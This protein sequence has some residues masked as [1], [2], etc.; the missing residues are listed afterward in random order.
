[1]AYDHARVLAPL[2]A[3]PSE[4]DRRRLLTDLMD[5][6]LVPLG[7]AV[8]VAGLRPGRRS[9]TLRI[10]SEGAVSEVPVTPG[11]IQMV[12]L[13]PGLTATAELDLR[14]GAWLGV[15]ARR[16][17]LELSGGL[18]GLLVDT[19]GIP[20]RLPDRAERRR[21]LLEAWQRPLWLADTP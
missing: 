8:L 10:G 3:I 5:D 1:M 19:R 14:E 21:E 2:G 13:P 17:S 9:G 18:G 12:D 15:R 7:S 11:G 20:L 16:L 4:D 6:V